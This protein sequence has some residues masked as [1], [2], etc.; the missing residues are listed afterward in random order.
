MKPGPAT[1]TT[2]SRAMGNREF[3]DTYARPGMVGLAAGNTVIDRLIAKAQRHVELG[4]GWGRWS[5][6]F[7]IGERRVDGFLWVIESDLEIHSK[8]IRLG[9]QENRIT[10]FDDPTFYTSI[11]LLDFRLPPETVTRLLAGGLDLVS[12]RA[13]YSMRELIGTLIALRHPCLRAKPNPLAR[14]ESYYCSA[15]V[16]LLFAKAGVDLTPGLDVKNTTPEDLWRSPLAPAAWLLDGAAPASRV[17]KLA[18]AVEH[19]V[20]ARLRQGRNRL[21]GTSPLG[22]PA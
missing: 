18:Q 17:A 12:A 9:A 15:L 16:R 14:P 10:K 5:H 2:V 7:V 4:T 8:N 22:G 13:R 11:A 3:F 6:A 19:R 20:R 21:R 1:V